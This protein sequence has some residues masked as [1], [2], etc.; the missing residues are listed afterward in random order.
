MFTGERGPRERVLPHQ[1]DFQL[2]GL[3]PE[4]L[5]AQT[6]ELGI[7]VND[8]AKAVALRQTPSPPGKV[9]IVRPSLYF[10]DI[11]SN[12]ELDLY[13]ILERLR[14]HPEANVGECPWEIPFLVAERVVKEKHTVPYT[15]DIAV[16]KPIQTTLDREP[17]VLA[18][19][20]FDR[21]ASVCGQ[22]TGHGTRFPNFRSFIFTIPS[23]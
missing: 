3:S 16:M 14:E 20:M 22:N 1:E 7:K 10:I 9:T 6:E 13:E 21:K 4:I 17:Y 12:Q 11:F 19:S 15:W 23:K 2:P 8:L 5:I 18:L